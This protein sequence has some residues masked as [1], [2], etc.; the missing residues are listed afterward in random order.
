MK[1]GQGGWPAYPG[2]DCPRNRRL[3]IPGLL[4]A[5]LRALAGA[6]DVVKELKL[7]T[8]FRVHLYAEN[9]PGARSLALSPACVLFVGTRHK[10]KVYALED[11]DA[12]HR[13]DHV[14]TVARGL[15]K[16]NGAAFRDGG[17]YA[18]EVSRFFTRATTFPRATAAES[19]LPSM[20]HGTARSRLAIGRCSPRCASRWLTSRLPKV[21]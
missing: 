7:P 21:G 13:A 19:S 14:H 15:R 17:L 12:Y 5:F 9:L 20:A 10:G 11:R 4:V 2:T 16:P 6:S 8:D 3:S 1:R 18:S